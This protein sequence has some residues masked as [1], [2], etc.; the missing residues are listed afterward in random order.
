MSRAWLR[1]AGEI[2]SVEIVGLADIRKEQ[3]EQKKD[4][5]G[6]S[7]A[8][9]DTEYEPLLDHTKPDAVFDCTTPESH[10]HV[11]TAA[12]ERGCHVLGEK[13]LADSLEN[14]RRSVEAAK[15]AGRIYA[16]IQNRRYRPSIRNLRALLES[17]TAGP[18][19][20]VNS[21]FYLGPH[22]GGFRDQMRHPLLLDMAI[23]TFDQARFI[24]GAD[25][26]SVFCR[27]FNPRSSWYADSAS[28]TAIFTMT[29]G[30]VYT[31]RGSWAA[32]GLPT[33]WESEWRLIG[34]K[35]TIKWDGDEK[36]ECEIVSKTG[37][38][39]SEV[40]PV[41]P[42]AFRSQGRIGGHAGIIEE[43][44]D[45]V[46]HGGVPETVCTDNIKSL[47][48]VFAAIESA[49]TGTSVPVRW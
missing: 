40:E 3:A 9:V 7:D 25:A 14:A 46:L 36:I 6:L 43:F 11:T 31:Y 17:Q 39:M 4:E 42:A 32:E 49:E 16:V 22:F 47:A 8:V 30:L 41:D 5:F 19:T 12:L 2:D 13:P 23:H 48:M 45:C 18:L 27:A 20:T 33:S 29:D 24:T 28:A 1:A 15:K 10:V 26:E 37:A 44:A 34:E 21:D 35:G 38:F